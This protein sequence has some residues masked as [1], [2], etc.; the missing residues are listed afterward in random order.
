MGI[1]VKCIDKYRDTRGNIFGYLLVD[2]N[3]NPMT[4][5]PDDLKNKIKNREL[6][7]IN[8][9]LTSDNRLIDKEINNKLN[10]ANNESAFTVDFLDWLRR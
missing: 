2:M 7:V 5:T 6:N 3:N 8:M 4:I 9:T 10:K 1:K